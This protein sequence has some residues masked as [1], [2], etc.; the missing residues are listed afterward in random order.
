MKF[1]LQKSLESFEKP[2]GCNQYGAIHK[3]RYAI[4]DPLPHH[5]LSHISGPSKYITPLG[6]PFLSMHTYICLS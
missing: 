2:L 3:V 5:T 6:P 1:G 4:L